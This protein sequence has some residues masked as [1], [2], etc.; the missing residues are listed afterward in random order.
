MPLTSQIGLLNTPGMPDLPKALLPPTASAASVALFRRWLLLPPRA[1]VADA[2]RAACEQLGQLTCALPVRRVGS[3][4]PH[5]IRTYSW[6][7][8]PLMGSE[9]TQAQIRTPSWDPN[10][11]MGS[12]PTRGIRTLVSSDPKL[13]MLEPHPPGCCSA[14]HPMAV[15]CCHGLSRAVT[16]CHG[17]SRAVT[18]CHVLPRADAG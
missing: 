10:L 13:S 18:C 15:T 11:L 6:D 14:L 8:N 1:E 5:G 16:C 7:P 4:P 3:E 12:E 2:A 17:L 9:P